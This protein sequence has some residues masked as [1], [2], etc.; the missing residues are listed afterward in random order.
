M[1][2]P[3]ASLGDKQSLMIKPLD[4]RQRKI[5]LTESAGFRLFG[6]LYKMP[7]KN[8]NMLHEN[9]FSKVRMYLYTISILTQKNRSQN[10]PLVIVVIRKPGFG[11][12]NLSQLLTPFE[13]VEA[14]EADAG[15]WVV[16]AQENWRPLYHWRS[17]HTQ[18]DQND[19]GGERWRIFDDLRVRLRV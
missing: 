1:E 10:N 3:S 13:N 16:V 15:T 19:D 7:I 4:Y 11:K 8:Q 5:R 9:C 12:P 14:E 6:Y 18:D 17:Q 2:A